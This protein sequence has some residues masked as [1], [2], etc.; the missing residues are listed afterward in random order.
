MIVHCRYRY[1]GYADDSATC[2]SA[3]EQTKHSK[4]HWINLLEERF[5]LMQKIKNLENIDKKQN[6]IVI[7]T[8]GLELHGL[9]CWIRYSFI[10]ANLDK[11][12]KI[13]KQESAARRIAKD[14]IVLGLHMGLD[15]IGMELK[16][17]SIQSEE[18]LN[19]FSFFFSFHI[20]IAFRRQ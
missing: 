7:F 16:R 8:V 3:S 13:Q 10:I 4:V 1:R 15:W 2:E 11:V 19:N 20:L 5:F 12:F 18:N 6:N 14:D 17:H 9:D